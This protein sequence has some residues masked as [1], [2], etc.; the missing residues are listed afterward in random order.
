M[1]RLG[2]VGT[3]AITSA[4][5]KGLAETALRDWPV[6][7]SPRSRERADEL[8]D[9]ITS[10]SIASDNQAVVDGSD[11]VFLAIRPQIAPDVI[12]SLSFRHGQYVVRLVAGIKVGT[13]ANLSSAHVPRQS[14]LQMKRSRK[15][16]MHLVRRFRWATRLFLTAMWLAAQLWRPISAW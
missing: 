16:S 15:Y 2:F 10:V 7:V 1:K 14:C 11:M 9:A 3:G 12:R 5:V 8:A 6:I 4:I 13:V